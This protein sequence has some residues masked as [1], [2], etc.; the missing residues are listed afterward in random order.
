MQLFYLSWVIIFTKELPNSTM[1]QFDHIDI[2]TTQNVRLHYEVSAIGDRIFAYLIDTSIVYGTA[3][4]INYLYFFIFDNISETLTI[5]GYALT[6][7]PLL[8]YHVVLEIFNDGQSIGKKIMKIRVIRMDGTQPSIGNYAI[9]WLSRI[10]EITGVGY[11]I[12]IIVILI[13]GKGQRLGDIA[14]GT[15]VA[16]VKNRTTLADTILAFSHENYQPIYIKSKLLSARDI[17]V[18]KEAIHFFLKYRNKHILDTCAF[19]VKTL[20][21]IDIQ[22]DTTNNYTFLNDVVNDYTYFKSQD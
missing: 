2:Q 14:G 8:F 4:L 20:F 12:A 16:K 21:G 3:L 13:N 7:I 5:I 15:T 19:K 22:T 9:R 17:E 11:G 18:I 6:L 10:I 1:N